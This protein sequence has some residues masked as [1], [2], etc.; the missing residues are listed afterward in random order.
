MTISRSKKKD[1]GHWTFTEQLDFENAYGFIY[2]IRHKHSGVMYIGKKFFRGAGKSNKGKQSN[3]RTYTSSSKELNA[4]ISQDGKDAFEFFIL[5][6][7]MT[8]G[9]VS[10]AETWSQCHVEVPT[11]NHIWLNR[12]IDKVQWKSSE[13]ITDRHKKRLNKLAGL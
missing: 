6:Q 7:Y 13:A 2:L 11:N 9:A 4:L 1:N 10:W 3:W 5:E 12:F 8:R